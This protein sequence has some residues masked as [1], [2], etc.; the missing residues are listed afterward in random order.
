[1]FAEDRKTIPANCA[2]E[3]IFK[4]QLSLTLSEAINEA[5]TPL[6]SLIWKWEF[7]PLPGY[8]RTQ[9]STMFKLSAQ[10]CGWGKVL[11]HT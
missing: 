1:M 9:V 6:V 2:I 4:K 10:W 8:H 3:N 5:M 11:S 7:K